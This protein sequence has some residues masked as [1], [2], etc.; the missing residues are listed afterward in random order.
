ML[1][2]IACYTPADLGVWGAFARLLCVARLRG[3]EAEARIR[4]RVRYRGQRLETTHN[5]GYVDTLTR[6]YVLV[7]YAWFWRSFSCGPAVV[8]RKDEAIAARPPSRP[9][10]TRAE[11][12]GRRRRRRGSWLSHCIMYTEHQKNKLVYVVVVPLLSREPRGC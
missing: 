7:H 5:I 3:R 6:P 10:R 8:F 11:T 12:G 9:S 2:P 1:L 4:G